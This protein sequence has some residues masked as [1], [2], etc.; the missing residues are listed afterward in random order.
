M[1]VN[2]PMNKLADEYCVFI[3]VPIVQTLLAV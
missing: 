1:V 3:K 2:T